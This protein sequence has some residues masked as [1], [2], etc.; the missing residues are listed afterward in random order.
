MPADA[1]RRRDLMR[2]AIH[3][4]IE[5]T[6]ETEE[7][8]SSVPSVSSLRQVDCDDF[9]IKDRRDGHVDVTGRLLDTRWSFA[10]EQLYAAR[11]GFVWQLDAHTLL[12][13][14]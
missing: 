9:M 3:V 5:T 1:L 2:L 4:T 8:V 11:P 13:Q 10:D 7:T 14:R 12:G 6:A